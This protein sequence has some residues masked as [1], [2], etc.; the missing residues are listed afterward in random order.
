[1]EAIRAGALA[2]VAVWAAIALLAAW[3]T[4]ILAAPGD[5]GAGAPAEERAAG[6]AAAPSPEAEAGDP[7]DTEAGTE[8]P[9][10]AEA[11]PAPDADAE[12]EPDDAGDAESGATADEDKPPKPLSQMTREEIFE[13]PVFKRYDIPWEKGEALLGDVKDNTFDYDEA[14][15]YWLVA[16]VAKLPAE[17]MAP[18][19]ET[20]DYKTLMALPSSF[21]GKPV[22]LEGV[23][24]QVAPIRT[25]VLAL[26]KEVPRFWEVTLRKPPLDQVL[27]VAT[28]IVTE[29]PMTTIERF[30][31][32]RVKGYFYKVRRYLGTKGEGLA[33]M[34]IAQRLELAGGPSPMMAPTVEAPGGLLL[35]VGGAVLILML[36]VF[37]YVRRLGRPKAHAANRRPGHRIRLRRPG[38]PFPAEDAG[39][40]D[41]SAG[42]KP[43]RGA[44]DG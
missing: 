17:A 42:P 32:V 23:Y 18:D 11:P 43:D 15:F 31:E 5:A 6:D 33:P 4:P 37:F 29:N 21:R 22:T 25:P 24:M 41:A 9:G 12:G 35:A 34:L 40:A 10:A 44:G 1:M 13:L 2:A 16:Q 20:T 26:Y 14:A 3:P 7:D 39:G 28:V 38:E 27:P 8:P 30:D 36:V 19:E